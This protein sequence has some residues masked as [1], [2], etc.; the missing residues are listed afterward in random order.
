MKKHC[1]ILLLTLLSVTINA[2]TLK[3]ISRQVG[4]LNISI[5]P[6]LELLSAVQ[7]ASDY[8]FIRRSGAYSKK[9][10]DY[11]GQYKNLK[12][13]VMTNSLLSQ[14]G[15]SYDAPVFLMLY[16]GQPLALKQR[17]AYS[18]YLKKRAGGSKNLEEYRKALKEF[19]TESD[20]EKFWHETKPL[21]NKVLELTVSELGTIDWIGILE[22]YYGKG[23]VHSHNITISP[24]FHGGYGPRLPSA[25]GGLDIY[26][27]L[28]T[29]GWEKDGV[30]YIN[31]TSLA[32]YMWHEFGHSYINPLGERYESRINSSASLFAPLH[33]VMSKQ[34]YGT[35]SAC[36]NEHLVRAVHMR[37]IAMNGSQE[38]YQKSVNQHISQGFI[39]LEPLLEKLKEY[40][41]QKSKITFDEFYPRLLDVLDSLSKT[42][43]HINLSGFRGPINAVLRGQTTL[44]YP[45]AGDSTETLRQYTAMVY[46][47]FLKRNG[48]V[49]MADTVALKS[50]L[51]NCS[52]MI[53]GTPQSNLFLKKHSTDFPFI[54]S[55]NKITAD[56]E[57]TN[58]GVKFITC[59]PN[60]F[61][62]EH[63]MVIYTATAD[64]DIIGINN[65][66]HGPE[67]FIVFLD[68][69]NVLSKG[70]YNKTNKWKFSK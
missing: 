68:K 35:W 14:Y 9:I 15:F 70:F 50:D 8:E 43:N 48:S 13:P 17:L 64:K 28:P 3:P 41:T 66:F 62:N 54:I 42:D 16:F 38:E 18:D 7:I 69:D 34:A 67:D 51:S 63:G 37:L 32:Y 60:P 6:R 46:E 65:V 27:C 10:A 11:F 1:L 5:D 26:G 55:D 25:K 33:E 45:T 24:A 36:V 40:E 23:S 52:L 49:L 47:R 12:A 21:Y 56:K 22:N 61:N 29:D 44:I 59:L 4:K 31:L 53:Y 57:Y 58:K 2:E 30:P 20:F 19:S 39:Y